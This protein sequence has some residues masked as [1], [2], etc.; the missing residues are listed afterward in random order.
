M[1]IEKW[2]KLYFKELFRFD[3]VKMKIALVNITNT[4]YSSLL[5]TICD[6]QTKP[7]KL[8]KKLEIWSLEVMATD[9][10]PIYMQL[11]KTTPNRASRRAD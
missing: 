8:A 9:L 10:S 7:D 5:N 3:N 11:Q 2:R 6:V 1:I 4:T